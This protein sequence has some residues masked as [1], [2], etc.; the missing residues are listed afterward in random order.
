MPDSRHL[1]LTRILGPEAHTLSM[2]D[3][4]NG[5]HGVF[6]VSPEAPRIDRG[7]GQRSTSCGARRPDRQ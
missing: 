1:V 5:D 2:L 4:V 3:T 7:R 6:Y